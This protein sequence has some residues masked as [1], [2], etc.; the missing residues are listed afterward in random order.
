MKTPIQYKH[1]IAERTKG[2]PQGGVI[3]PLL[4]NLFLHYV[5]DMFLKKNHPEIRWARY[6]DDGVIH[7]RTKQEAETMLQVLAARL[8]ECDL[9]IHPDKTKIVYCGRRNIEG[10]RAFTFLGYTFRPRSS[11]DGRTGEVF[12]NF[13]PA[14][15]KEQLKSIRAAIRKDNIRARTD[16]S[17]EEI[18][19]KYNPKIRGW[20]N[21]YGKFYPSSLNKLWKYFNRVLMLWAKAK[22][23]KV[24]T[25][26]RK[27][28][29]LIQKLQEECGHLFYHW[30]LKQGKK[31]YV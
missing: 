7:C 8:K 11:V 6:A 13:L 17:I 1:G 12:T 9:E 18:A 19:A 25:S 31:I 14:I 5:I 16:L 27:A 10:N 29:A 2:T 24:R 4:S 23:K 20:Y 30:K 21:Y 15:S 22:Y 3:S 26:T 28:V